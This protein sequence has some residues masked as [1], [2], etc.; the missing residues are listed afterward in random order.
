MLTQFRKRYPQGSLIS[1]LVDIDRG[2]Y[3]V[4]AL[5]Q[6]EGVTI[7]TGLASCDTIEQAEDRA[8]E[9][10]LSLLDLNEEIVIH[11]E[12]T[13]TKSQVIQESEPVSS[14][15]SDRF[16]TKEHKKSIASISEVVTS[17]D[18]V[19]ASESFPSRSNGATSSKS[20]TAKITNSFTSEPQLDIQETI[21]EIV[22][23][24][25]TKTFTSKPQL[26]IQ[27]TTP[28]IAIPEE[29]DEN[30]A[31]V[32]TTTQPTFANK[33]NLSGSETE[34]F[35]ELIEQTDREIKRLG[36]TKEQGRDYLLQA[37]GKRSRLM[38]TDE[39]LREFL[40]YLKAQS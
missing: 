5:V 35:D 17:Q 28:E 38:L 2:K 31:V 18:N 30:D 36:W 25:E 37:Y 39:E 29:K 22:T 19:E 11:P 6:V 1:E 10:A 33:D 20:K 7:A 14:K 4:R 8:R 26:D 15:E 13:P 23:P 16:T 32:E 21:P 12:L 9:R 27:E 24:K 34:S 40:H 3:I